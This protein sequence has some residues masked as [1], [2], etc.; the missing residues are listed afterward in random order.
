VPAGV[1]ANCRQTY[2]DSNAGNNPC[3]ANVANPLQPVGGPLLPFVGTLA[4][5]N[6]PMVDTYYPYL[7][8][9]GD[10]VQRDQGISDYDSL[11]IRVRHTFARGL[12]VDGN[13]T[14]SKS[15]DSGYTELQDLQGFADNVGSGAG[16]ANGV[17]DLMNWANNRK[18]S[19]TDVPHRVIVTAVYDLPFGPGRS[20]AMSNNKAARATLG[21]WRLSYVFT[22]QRGFPLS[23]TGANGNSLDGRPNRNAAE[24]LLLPSSYQKWYDG[25]TSITLPDGRIYTPCAQCFLKYNPD[26]FSGQVLTTANGGRQTDLYWVG[27]AA[28]DYGDMRG[29]G[30]SNVDVTLSRDFRVHEKYVIAFMANVTNVF[31]HTQFRTGSFNM[32]LGGIQVTDVPA[33]GLIAGFGQSAASYGTHNLNTFDPRQMILEMRVRF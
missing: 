6:I 25:K 20:L 14:W 28:I 23:P 15:L 30:R 18:L 32:G 8:L 12:Q 26:A 3:N 19:Y 16:G 29:P 21:G 2:I 24:P 31:N 7:P 5:A 11:R 9:L 17:L 4:Q 13:Y 10:S 1:L 33:Q 27:N 22:W